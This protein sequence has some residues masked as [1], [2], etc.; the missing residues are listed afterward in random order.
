M[1]KRGF[2]VGR[3]NGAGGKVSGGETIEEATIR[4]TQEEIGVRVKEISK[5]AELTFTFPHNESWNQVVHVYFCSKWDGEIVESE[6]MKPKWFKV[7]DIPY[8]SMWPDDI[9]WL[10]KVLAGEKIRASFT[11]GKNDVILKK[12][13]EIEKE[14]R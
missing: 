6:E 12:K 3:F 10:P 1:K 4:E 5:I 7:D 9:F 2:G 14:L 13:V 8:S 11:F